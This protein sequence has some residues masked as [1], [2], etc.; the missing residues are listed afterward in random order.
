[1]SAFSLI[2]MGGLIPRFRSP[3][4]WDMP[5][6]YLLLACYFSDLDQGCSVQA[7][8]GRRLL[9]GAKPWGRGGLGVTIVGRS[10]CVVRSTQHMGGSR[11]VQGGRKE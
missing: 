6:Y 9:Q 7:H 1:M 10:Y 4:T 5:S 3:S 2:Y 8:G 11:L